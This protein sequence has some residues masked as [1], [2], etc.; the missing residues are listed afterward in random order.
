MKNAISMIVLPLFCA[1][2]ALSQTNTSAEFEKGVVT[3]HVATTKD[4]KQS[5]A[6]YLPTNYTPDKKWPILYCFDPMARGSVP[7]KRFQKAAEKFGYIVAGSNNSRNSLPP[8]DL[9]TT[10][11]A[12]WG[13]THQRF[14]IDEKRVYSC[15]LSGGARVASF[16]AFSCKG[17]IRGVIGNGAGFMSDL[18]P[19]A[20]MPFV[21]FGTA[22][23]EDFNYPE[24]K[25]LTAKLTELG[26]QN[27]FDPFDGKHEWLTEAMAERALLWMELRAMRDGTR[28]KNDALID[29]AYLSRIAEAKKYADQKNVLDSYRVYAG[30]ASDFAGLRDVTKEIEIVG[31]LK[32]SAELRS[33]IRD[34]ED[35]F[36]QQVRTVS[37]LYALSRKMK[38][39]HAAPASDSADENRP[40]PQQEFRDAINGLKKNA[41]RKDNSGDQL[42]ARRA[43]AELVVGFWETS[44][45]AERAGDLESAASDIELI[46]QIAPENAYAWYNLARLNALQ[47]KTKAAFSAL[48]KAV[49]S[50]FAERAILEKEKAFDPLRANERFQKILA[51]LKDK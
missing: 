18:K 27:Y 42:V 20:Q 40:D 38:Q 9:V 48:E 35:Q 41:T 25:K 43:M 50:G 32:I 31:K 11:Q 39:K 4:P 23:V 45:G 26:V 49:A 33:A 2:A 3:K 13:D 17:C 7:V 34:E 22:G 51:D 1:V 14:S 44:G 10:L 30:T 46:T 19:T 5:Y 28:A 16:F 15:G 8:K 21:F 47:K 24:L 36:A 6:L 12:L 37:T 29:A